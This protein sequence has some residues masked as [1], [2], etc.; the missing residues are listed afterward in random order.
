MYGNALREH[1]AWTS[2]TR[3]LDASADAY[4][5]ATAHATSAERADVR[6]AAGVA[7]LDT[8]RRTGDLAHLQVAI[9]FLSEAVRSVP[10]DSPWR[11]THLSDLSAAY[12]LRYLHTGQLRDLERAVDMLND[13]AESSPAASPDRGAF[14]GARG[15]LWLDMFNHTGALDGI[16]YAVADLTESVAGIPERAPRRADSQASLATALI[17]RSEVADAGGNIQADRADT[18]NAIVLLESAL[19]L[20]PETATA[21]P[22]Y[23][24]KLGSAILARYRR[25]RRES[26]LDRT[27]ELLEEAVRSTPEPTKDLAYAYRMR[28]DA[29]HRDHDLSRAVEFYEKCCL[30]GMAQGPGQIA[31]VGREWGDWALDRESWAEAARAY[32]YCLDNL[33][34]LSAANAARH[35]KTT[36]LEP[37]S[38]VPA[39]IAYACARAGDPDTGAAMFEK[40]RAFLLNETAEWHRA[41]AA[42]HPDLYVRLGAALAAADAMAGAVRTAGQDPAARFLPSGQVEQVNRDLDQ[43]LAEITAVTSQQAGHAGSAPARLGEAWIIRLAPGP[44]SGV[45]IITAPGEPTATTIPLPEAAE[46][47]IGDRLT[48]LRSPYAQRRTAPSVWQAT[49][50]EV[51]G[52]LGRA[53]GRSLADT[54]PSDADAVVIGGAALT[55]RRPYGTPG[56]PRRIRDAPEALRTGSGCQP[57]ATSTRTGGPDSPIPE[58]ETTWTR[59]YS[60]WRV[61]SAP[62]LRS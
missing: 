29:R 27:V 32:R 40:G 62:I 44:R 15:I 8:Y 34:L 43:V 18:D 17:L 49:L 41:L 33:M 19:T 58:P 48:A 47:D 22:G 46:P 11:P 35:H 54:L 61:P 59:T 57:A 23:L 28:W 42:D 37:A 1:Y 52:W 21:R 10:P 14:L 12:R 39:R 31:E 5:R 7:T 13:A 4:A 30:P 6:A 3:D 24:G 36:W 56:T 51:T 50:D 55:S 60:M 38:R 45:A 20:V 2:D 9:D 25:D 16:D 26:D 53:V